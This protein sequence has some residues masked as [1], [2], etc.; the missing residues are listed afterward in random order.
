[1]N[2]FTIP[3]ILV[4]TIFV[5]GIFAF[6]PVE[7]AST[8]HNTLQTASSAT[9]AHDLLQ[10]LTASTTHDNTLLNNVK[11]TFSNDLSTANV[12]ASCSSGSFL[13]YWTFSNGTIADNADAQNEITRLGI[14]NS[15]GTGV[16]FSIP[17]FLGNFTS[18]SG[19]HG[20]LAGETIV[21]TGNST[22]AGTDQSFEDTGD[23]S[24]T[25]VCQKGATAGTT[26]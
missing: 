24:I 5:A 14:Q 1:M 8:V 18:V 22:N 19:V 23:V 6:M 3:V 16:D 17:L 26:P 20:G 21:F 12:T 7:K 2:K 25:V 13:V 11:W 9:S 4:V 15:T 10:T